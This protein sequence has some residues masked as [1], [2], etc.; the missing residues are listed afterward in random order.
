MEFTLKIAGEEKIFNLCLAVQGDV[1]EF[2]DMDFVEFCDK[3]DRNP[4]KYKPILMLHAYNYK[5]KSKIDIDTINDWLEKDGG[6]HSGAFALFTQK[7]IDYL[8]KD[9]PIQEKKTKAKIIK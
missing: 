7:Y 6:V 8:S 1:L 2:L 4:F 3:I 9:V 5:A